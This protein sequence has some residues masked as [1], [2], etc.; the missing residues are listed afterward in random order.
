[1]NMGAILEKAAAKFA[2]ARALILDDRELTFAEL[3]EV[4]NRI[5]NVLRGQGV[6][7]GDR[8]ALLLP[9]GLP[10]IASFFA[11]MKIGAVINP[12]NPLFKGREITYIVNNS[13]AKVLITTADQMETIE[14]VRD[15]LP[16][17]GR[18]ILVDAADHPGTDF[19]DDLIASAPSTLAMEDCDP[20]H[21]LFLVYTSG[22]TGLP[23]GATITHRNSLADA[24]L[25]AQVQFFTRRDLIITGLP[26]FHL[27][28]GNV[29]LNGSIIAG[30]TLCVL[31][32]FDPRRLLEKT[33]LIEANVFVGV[34]TMFVYVNREARPGEGRSLERAITAGAPMP[35]EVMREFEAKF[36]AQVIELYGL[37][38]TAGAVT[39][40][41]MYYPAKPGSVGLAIPPVQVKIVD[42]EG[43]GGD[44]AAGRIGEL[45]IRGPVVMKEYWQLPKETAEAVVDGWLHTGDLAEMD[46]DGFIFLKGRKK[47][48]IITGG[49]NVY[50]V[51]I[52]DVIYEHPAVSEVA[53]VGIPDQTMGEIAKAFVVLRPGATATPEEITAHCDARLARYKVP[54]QVEFISE[55]PKNPVGK[56]LKRVLR[57]RERTSG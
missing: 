5:G 25:S 38:E 46:E 8:V 16:T 43:R 7:K 19:L 9:N 26:V 15:E 31:G 13:G 20:D 17:L 18:V 56:I 28:G 50:P 41:P 27:F 14:A 40:A 24:Q 32:R 57:E 53:V 3:D 54:R 44:V 49:Y 4:A 48:M 6:Q 23:K 35:L 21:P 29:V 34:P 47:E 1:M 22:T 39:A 42:A 11:I 2:G 52:E 30:S 12:L 51:E 10:S 37:T 33:D 45:C 55:I 36:Q